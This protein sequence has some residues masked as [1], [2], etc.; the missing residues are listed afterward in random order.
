MDIPK[1]QRWKFLQR[2]YKVKINHN[3]K[4][5]KAEIKLKKEF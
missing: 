5:F 1:N 2:F 3:E 4:S